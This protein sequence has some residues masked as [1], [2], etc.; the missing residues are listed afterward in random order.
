MSHRM[1]LTACRCREKA[2]DTY[3]NHPEAFISHQVGL[4]YEYLECN[5]CIHM[6][7]LHDLFRRAEEQFLIN[8]FSRVKA[9]HMLEKEAEERL[10]PVLYK[11][12][13]QFIRYTTEQLE[14]MLE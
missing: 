10:G 3:M 14:D 9:A 13:D 8:L 6:R 4:R 7:V 12:V 11:H 1:P 2:L 5:P